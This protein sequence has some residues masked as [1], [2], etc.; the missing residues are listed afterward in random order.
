MIQYFNLIC[1]IIDDNFKNNLKIY[2]RN[3]ALFMNVPWKSTLKAVIALDLIG[4]MLCKFYTFP[5]LFV[6]LRNSSGAQP[7]TSKSLVL[8]FMHTKFGQNWSRTFRRDVENMN[9]DTPLWSLGDIAP[10]ICTNIHV[11][12]IRVMHKFDKN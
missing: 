9:F 5:P 3:S 4:N 2:R 6:P 11:L 12:A 10:P 1:V 8:R 7:Q